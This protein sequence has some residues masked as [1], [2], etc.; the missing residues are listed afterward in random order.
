MKTGTHT[1]VPVPMATAHH[2]QTILVTGTGTWVP[3]PT[4]LPV[5]SHGARHGVTYVLILA[6][7]SL[8]APVPLYLL[9]VALRR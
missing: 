7:A 1:Q 4:A 9:R 6:C 5:V 8:P 2:Q 3:V